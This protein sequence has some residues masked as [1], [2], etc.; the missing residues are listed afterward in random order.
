MEP[1]CETP[2]S[3]PWAEEEIWTADG[4]EGGAVRVLE[5]TYASFQDWKAANPSYDHSV[6]TGELMRDCLVLTE[7]N[8]GTNTCP[9][10]YNDEV[11]TVVEGDRLTLRF[12]AFAL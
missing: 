7:E 5:G 10:P 11:L 2:P 3:I 8:D 12:A 1:I 9:V 6:C 4:S